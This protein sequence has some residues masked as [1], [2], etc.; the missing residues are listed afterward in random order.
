MRKRDSQSS[1]LRAATPKRLKE[2]DEDDELRQAAVIY[3]QDLVSE[4]MENL[5]SSQSKRLSIVKKDKDLMKK[6]LRELQRKRPAIQPVSPDNI[7]RLEVNR[8]LAEEQDVPTETSLTEISMEG[9]AQETPRPRASSPRSAPPNRQDIPFKPSQSLTEDTKL[10]LTL[11]GGGVRGIIELVILSEIEKMSGVPI[12]LA[13]DLMVG[14]STGGIISLLLNIPDDQDP[15]MPK[16]SAEECLSLY[17]DYGK[18]IFPKKFFHEG[19]FRIKYGSSVIADV[20]DSYFGSLTMHE[21]LTKVAV[22][23]FDPAAYSLQILKNYSH[24]GHN[25]YMRDAALAT[26]AAPTYLKGRRIKKVQSHQGQ[27]H[28]DRNAPLQYAI[29]GGVG[30]VNNPGMVALIDAYEQWG[31]SADVVMV[32]LGTGAEYTSID[33]KDVCKAGGVKWLQNGLIN[34]LLDAPNNATHYWLETLLNKIQKQFPDLQKEEEEIAHL[35]AQLERKKKKWNLT[36]EQK[37]QI[38][39]DLERVFT[40]MGQRQQEKN[41]NRNR[42]Q[43]YFRLQPIIDSSMSKLDNVSSK[44][45]YRLKNAATRYVADHVT[46]IRELA[47]IFKKR[48]EIKEAQAV[49]AQKQ[50]QSTL[51]TSRQAMG[52][53]RKTSQEQPRH[54]KSESSVSVQD[55]TEPTDAAAL[56]QRQ[57]SSLAKD[58]AAE[59]RR[60]AKEELKKTRTAKKLAKGKGSADDVEHFQRSES[61]RLRVKRIQSVTQEM[62]QE[63]AHK[64][65]R[66]RNVSAPAEESGLHRSPSESSLRDVHPLATAE[67]TV[68]PLRAATKITESSS[69]ETQEQ[70]FRKQKKNTQGKKNKKSKTHIAPIGDDDK[71]PKRKKTKRGSHKASTT[72]AVDASHG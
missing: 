24:H 71:P 50:A 15:N 64:K 20:A 16:Y 41:K 12:A 52:Q 65:T 67:E 42:T 39:A 57:V 3:G 8:T 34:L 11:D 58:D 14:T 13:C 72:P 36:N 68:K 25:Y 27:P 40:D 23:S 56:R 10:V 55:P 37:Q 30:G 62:G 5:R 1:S 31:D 53:G 47:D 49:R 26:S 21:A 6:V 51:K 18:M 46:I 66:K 17:Y 32:S 4:T 29:D 45:L 9:S 69:A 70:N 63:S 2:K 7:R 28:Y 61:M 33:F 44:N 54:N 48:F 60:Q 59:H 35:R 43:N 22:T 38:D 19:I